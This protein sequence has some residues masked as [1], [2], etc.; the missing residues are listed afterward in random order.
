L[1]RN[2]RLTGELSPAG[3]IDLYG[4]SLDEPAEILLEAA[5]VQGGIVPCLELRSASDEPLAERQCGSPARLMPELGRGSYLVR[6]SDASGDATGT[7][8]VLVADPTMPTPTG[9]P[10]P[11]T[12]TATPTM[13]TSTETPT[14][15]STPSPT[16][17][18][19]P[20]TFIVDS[21]DDAADADP[22]NGSCATARGSCT[23]RAAIEEA[24]VSGL[25]YF[26]HIPPGTYTLTSGIRLLV[27]GQMTLIGAGSSETII[28]AADE[29]SVT[30]FGV[31]EI[32]SGIVRL[33]G[34]TIRHG[35]RMNFAG[36]LQVGEDAIVTL[37]DSILSQN[38]DAIVNA[39]RL[40][41][42]DC[43]V[44]ADGER[45]FGDAITNRGTLGVARTSISPG[46]GL[47]AGIVNGGELTF[48]DSESRGGLDG[49]FNE[50]LAT[51]TVTDS[52]LRDNTFGIRNLG[53]AALERC[54]IR[55]NRTL[56]GD[57]G[58]GVTNSGVLT[59]IDTVVDDNTA[60][61]GAGV[62]N[63]G[64]AN[65]RNCTI[66]G[67]ETSGSG[68][69]GSGGG[70][71]N[72]GTLEMTNCT[73][74]GNQALLGQGGGVI[75][76]AGSLTMR[77]CTVSGNTA[78]GGGGVAAVSGNLRLANALVAVN[79]AADGPDCLGAPT[80]LGYNLI[81]NA[82]GCDPTAAEGDLLGSAN[83]PIDPLLGPLQDNGG[84]TLTHA[85]L[86]A[87]PA[88]DAAD[89]LP[90]GSGGNACEPSDQRG[91]SRPQG[92]R[93]DIGAYEAPVV[94]P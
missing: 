46:G 62:H 27:Q 81:G 86:F 77:S 69:M 2:V 29:P 63:T 61:Y 38:V 41:I 24:N 30:T 85:L 33:S 73:V 16:A 91:V 70:I 74:S 34:M 19:T 89:P 10:E 54:S 23:I 1:V 32:P 75:N 28:Q 60:S 8:G 9:T 64:M 17:T 65:L 50:L 42:E 52:V 51:A 49:I 13:P 83:N 88:I 78:G 58:A 45:D 14:A 6:V 72:S 55:D 12:A 48:A 15:T 44:D 68:S 94:Q 82:A 53:V 25:S 71:W 66:S 3:D 87:S 39:G 93:C 21:T 47:S 56:A 20:G 4:F 59:M 31:F 11:P 92:I 26:I 79:S 37:A 35:R 22:G 67:N 57:P 80:S 18:A 43:R 90:P 7:Y 5:L 76:E 40:T 84:P 36:A